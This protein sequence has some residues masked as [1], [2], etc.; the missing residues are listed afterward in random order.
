MSICYHSNQHAMV[1]I[2]TLLRSSS[3]HSLS[4]SLIPSF[5]SQSFLGFSPLLFLP[6]LYFT[7]TTFCLSLNLSLTLHFLYL[8]PSSTF[9][10]ILS[11]SHFLFPP[12]LFLIDFSLSFSLFFLLQALSLSLSL[13]ISVS[14]SLPRSTQN[15]VEYNSF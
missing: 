7:L 12:S 6:Q 14:L 5:L 8:S 2:A 9:T 4:L 3:S 1:S 15:K 10:P 13:S 11:F